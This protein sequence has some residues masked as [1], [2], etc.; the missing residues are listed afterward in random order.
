MN[1]CGKSSNV[2]RVLK[3]HTETHKTYENVKCGICNRIISSTENLMLHEKLHNKEIIKVKCDLCPELVREGYMKKH[4]KVY[5]I[6]RPVYDICKKV[7]K[8][9]RHLSIMKQLILSG[10]DLSNAAFAISKHIPAAHYNL[11]NRSTIRLHL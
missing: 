7:L 5:K 1:V 10:N 9:P 8:I 3:K 4:Q 2:A 11:H 6:Q